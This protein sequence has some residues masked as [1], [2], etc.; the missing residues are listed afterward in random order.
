MNLSSIQNPSIA[1]SIVAGEVKQ[2]RIN[3]NSEET[4]SFP[5]HYPITLFTQIF[6]HKRLDYI[7]VHWHNELQVIWTYEGTLNYQINEETIEITGDSLLIINKKQFH[8]SKTI[9]QNAKTLCINFHFDFLHPTILREYILPLIGNESFAYHLLYLSPEQRMKL[10]RMIEEKEKAINFFSVANFLLTVFE[11]VI[12]EFEYHEKKSFQ[13]EVQLFNQLLNYVHEN[14]QYSITIED[15]AKHGSINRN[16]CTNLFKKY[17]QLSPIKYVNKHRLYVARH[18]IIET[19]ASIS[20]ISEEVGFNQV[21]YFVEQFR[22]CYQI[23][24]LKYRKKFRKI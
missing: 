10:R 5:S 20:D 16:L 23:S 15:L 17:T 6:N 3:E 24:P 21:S 1:K 19:D 2:V 13:K 4:I 18:L 12:R 22:K 7:P 11:E 8:S 14:Y 9:H